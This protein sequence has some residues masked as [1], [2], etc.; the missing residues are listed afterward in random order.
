MSLGFKLPCI[1]FQYEKIITRYRAL[2]KMLADWHVGEH[3][4]QTLAETEGS[5]CAPNFLDRI[6]LEAVS[7]VVVWL[8]SN[9]DPPGVFVNS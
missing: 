5:R 7:G 2:W 9:S 1:L 6:K 4:D 8:G 3:H